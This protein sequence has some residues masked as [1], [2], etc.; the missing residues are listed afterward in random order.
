MDIDLFMI[1]FFFVGL[2]SNNDI[3]ICYRKSYSKNNK[4]S[5]L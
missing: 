3:N 4:N 2:D 1:M 5:S